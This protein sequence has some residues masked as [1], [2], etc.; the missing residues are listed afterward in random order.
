ML[1]VLGLILLV[2]AVV[3]GLTGVVTNADSAHTL[4][5]D[6]SIFGF[7]AGGSTGTL[8]LYGIVVGAIGIIGLGLLLAG[9]R[10]SSRRGQDARRGLKQ[11]RQETAA[12]IQERDNMADQRDAARAEGS[13][14]PATGS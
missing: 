12:A 4:T 6:F 10:R 13:S 2:A 3:V 7:D 11:S 8:F 14:R 9:A 1:V 5:N